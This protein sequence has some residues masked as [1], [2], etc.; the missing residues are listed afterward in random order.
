MTEQKN[1]EQVAARD[2]GRILVPRGIKP[3]RRP[4]HVSLV[5]GI[6]GEGT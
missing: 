5:F 1:A 4:R 2:R 6:G 3:K